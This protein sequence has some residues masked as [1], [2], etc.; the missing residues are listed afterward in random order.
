M[1]SS[2]RNHCDT[3][4]HTQQTSG[5][6][7]LRGS[8]WT[9][10]ECSCESLKCG[11]HWSHCRHAWIAI[12]NEDPPSSSTKLMI[13]LQMSSQNAAA[14]PLCCFNL[15]PRLYFPRLCQHQSDLRLTV[16]ASVL[17]DSM[18]IDLTVNH[19][20]GETSAQLA[21]L[22]IN[23]FWLSTDPWE[24]GQKWKK[25]ATYSVQEWFSC[26]SEHGSYRSSGK[27]NATL[28]KRHHPAEGTDGLWAH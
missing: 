28:A 15:Y 18:P 24:K 12:I 14:L 1:I 3:R 23:E 20:F 27:N 7:V 16:P 26:R 5:I 2:K 22:N 10:K 21:N 11:K 6:D 17:Q 13:G 8:H 19:N 9:E 25:K 4:T